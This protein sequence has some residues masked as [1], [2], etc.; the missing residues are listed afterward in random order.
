MNDCQRWIA[1]CRYF[2]AR[3]WTFPGLNMT[4]KRSIQANVSH[5]QIFSNFRIFA[6]KHWKKISM[7]NLQTD[8][9]FV[10]SIPHRY[11][12][13]TFPFTSVRYCQAYFW[14]GHTR[15]TLSYRWQQSSRVIRSCRSIDVSN[16]WNRSFVL[17][18]RI[19]PM[20]LNT[21]G[22]TIVDYISRIRNVKNV[23][24]SMNSTG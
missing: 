24:H 5:V 14:Y 2:Q 4:A 22:N 15:T 10:S 1:C 20:M 18:E 23:K 9:T 21:F 17:F 19:M 3:I 11:F 16:H 13:K 12:T 7:V 8:H 6:W